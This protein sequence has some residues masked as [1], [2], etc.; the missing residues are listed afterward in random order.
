MT[1]NKK[2]L[3]EQAMRNPAEL[4]RPRNRKVYLPKVDIYETKDA[5]TLI[6]DMPGID[7]KSVEVLLEKN[8]LSLSGKSEP[9]AFQGYA[10]A[11]AEYDGGDYHREFTISDEID[12]DNIVASMKNGL[13]RLILPKAQKVKARKIA[14]QAE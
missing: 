2:E 14:I 12:K 13:F 9:L 1:E 11:Y 6:A 7:D 4:E 5:V 3:Q 10:I 8:V